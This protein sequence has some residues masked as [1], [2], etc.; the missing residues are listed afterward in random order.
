M[1]GGDRLRNEPVI[2]DG[3]RPTFRVAFVIC[4]IND[5]MVLDA[6]GVELDLDVVRV[7]AVQR[8]EIDQLF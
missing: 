3:Y 8:L 6:E 2:A 5:L 1:I 4:E 7:D